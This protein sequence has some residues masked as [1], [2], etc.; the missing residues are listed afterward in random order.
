MKKVKI[1]GKSVPVLL[2]VLLGVGL[3]SGALLTYFGQIVTTANVQQAVTL[4][5]EQTHREF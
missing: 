2:L 1:L 4:I 5:G 3:V